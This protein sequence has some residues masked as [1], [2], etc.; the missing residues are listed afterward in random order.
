MVI[1]ASPHERVQP[2]P[3]W[4]LPAVTG[5]LLG[6]MVGLLTPESIPLFRQ[7]LAPAS[8]CEERAWPATEISCTAARSFSVIYAPDRSPA[9][10][11][12]DVRIWLTTLDAV[13]TRLHPPRQ[14]AD[15]PSSGNAPVWLYIWENIA[16][17]DLGDRVLHVAAA[18]RPGAFVYVY[19]WPELGFP[20][21]PATMPSIR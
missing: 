10:G 6:G 15:H 9:P 19:R 13:D 21:V 7:E 11:R 2:R 5:I 1:D 12:W 20:A 8:S 4:F 16:G 18:S 3:W 17:A 14:V